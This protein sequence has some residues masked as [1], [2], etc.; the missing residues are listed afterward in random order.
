[1][2]NLSLTGEVLSADGRLS[3]R[4]RRSGPSTEAG[5][6]GAAAGREMLGRG[7]LELVSR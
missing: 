4:L 6:I 1:V 5:R 3:L 2:G 7:G